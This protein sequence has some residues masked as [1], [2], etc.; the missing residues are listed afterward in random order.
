MGGFLGV[1]AGS[2][3]FL[4]AIWSNLGAKF[5][6]ISEAF[7]A[8]LGPISGL[9]VLVHSRPVREMHCSPLRGV[10][11]TLPYADLYDAISC[12]SACAVIEDS[13]ADL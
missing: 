12:A 4:D 9:D 6:A 11:R 3:G 1:P 10:F 13:T 2:W 8:D 7:G 5:E